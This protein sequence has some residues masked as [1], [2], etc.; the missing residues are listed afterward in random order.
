MRELF[1]LLVPEIAKAGR[2]GQPLDVSFIAGQKMPARCGAGAIVCLYISALFGRGQVRCFA[3]IKAHRDHL[4]LI[5]DVE[6]HLPEGAH[7]SIQDLIT[8]HRT[9]V[10]DER[11]HNGLPWKS[12]PRRTSRPCS[13]LKTASSEI[14]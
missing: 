10:I 8:E 12:C 11:Q 4:E 1:G 2:F 9:L 5:A 6:R 7:H 14:C 13:S 3:R